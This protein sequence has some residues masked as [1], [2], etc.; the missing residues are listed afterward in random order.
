MTDTQKLLLD[1]FPDLIFE[2][3]KP[4]APITYFKIGGPAEVFTEIESVAQL[5]KLLP[6]T[7]ENGI[8]ITVLGG[9]SN[10]LISDQ[11]LPGLV[12]TIKSDAVEVKEKLQD[13]KQVVEAEAGVKNAVLVAK[14]MQLGLTGL[15]YFLG[16][17]GT[18]G[19]SVYN[20]A[21]YLNRLLDEHIHKI[22][23]IKND[24]SSLWLDHSECE[25]AYEKSR[26]QKTREII[27]KVQFA[28]ANGDIEASQQMVK[29]AVEYRAKTQPLGLASSGCIFQNVPNNPQLQQ[30]FP[31]FADKDFVPGGFIIDQAGLK[32]LQNGDIEVSEKHAAWMINKGQ[33]TAS[34][35]KNLIEEVKQKVA[36]KFGVNLQ[37][38]VFFLE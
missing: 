21:H 19:G 9:A 26:F 20:N 32:K 38:E 10:V 5:E 34:Q 6:F 7:L 17:P 2:M 13:E 31:Q 35:V 24:G 36:N 28:L 11:G 12:F 8:R 1:N 3:N 27:W 25:F 33:G 29:E 14:T 16:V 4:L 30:L 37:E 18:L 15:E 22:M 23:V